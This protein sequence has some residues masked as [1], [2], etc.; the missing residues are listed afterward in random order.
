[1]FG[2]FNKFKKGKIVPHASILVIEDNE[3]DRLFIQRTLEKRNH[4]VFTA[5]NGEE[6]LRLVYQHKI[7][8][9]ILDCILPGMS[10][11]KVCETLKQDE[12]TESIP[13]VF[14]SV[15]E[16]GEILEFY[17][18]GAEFYLHKPVTAKELL[19][20][21]QILLSESRKADKGTDRMGLP[22]I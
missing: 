15:V 4:L 16:G 10:G 7:D 17:G 22:P 18:A 21:V 1:M 8:L 6:G 2:L 3:V 14:L 5:G 13:V 9:I 12:R 20:E 11:L 19:R